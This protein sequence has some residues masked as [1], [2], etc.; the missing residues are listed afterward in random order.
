MTTTLSS[1][2]APPSATPYQTAAAAIAELTHGKGNVE[3]LRILVHSLVTLG[4]DSAARGVLQEV[5]IADPAWPAHRDRIIETLGT[6]GAV[7]W[8]SRQRRFNANLDVLQTRW[9]DLA[10]QLT[11]HWSSTQTRYQLYQTRDGGLQI[12]DRTRGYCFGWL[13]GL[14]D[15]RTERQ[16]WQYPR[17]API[18]LRPMCFDGA[19]YGW[20]LLH[21][22]PD[23]ERSLLSYSCAVY[24]VE[25]DLAALA[26]LLHL[27]DLRHW[28]S[29]P[30]LRLF[31]GAE[32]PN[33]FAAALQREKTWDVPFIHWCNR[34][35]DHPPLD[36]TP[37]C[38]VENARRQTIADAT[39]TTIQSYYQDK[40]LAY[41]RQRYAAALGGG[42]TPLRVLGITT[43]H[44][45]VLQYT[46]DELGQAIRAAGHECQVNKEPDDHSLESA[47]LEQLANFKP[48]LIIAISRLRYENP[49]IPQNVPCLC[50]DQ[51]ALPC[52]RTQRT[53]DSLDALTY[54][55]GSSA[56]EAFMAGRR[57]PLASS[58]FCHLA[59]ATHRYHAAP[60]APEAFARHACDISYVSNASEHPGAF[61]QQLAQRWH[62]SE[63]GTLFS[64]LAQ[65]TLAA[66]AHEE[67]EHVIADGIRD[68]ACQRGHD[69]NL[70]DDIIRELVADL[71]L[72]A[73][74]TLRHTL[75]H[76]VAAYCRKRGRTLRLYGAGWDQTPDLAEFAAGPIT[77]GEDL[78]A[79]YQASKIN[80]QI[81]RWGFTHSRSLDGLAAGGF[82][83]ANLAH[84]DEGHPGDAQRFQFATRA[85]ELGCWTTAEIRASSDPQ[86]R[87]GWPQF[88]SWYS[89]E[90]L[91]GDFPAWRTAAAI[92]IPG[93]VFE[94]LPAISFRDPASFETL[95]ERYL[96]DDTLRQ[97]VTDRMR[98]K[99]LQYYSYDTRW[100]Q[101]ATAILR[102]LNRSG[103]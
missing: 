4:L 80:L 60:V 7:A 1:P 90:E 47:C 8:S 98:Q 12:L 68:L 25:P 94:D 50:W 10:Q 31:G 88:S 3:V 61:A 28:L 16:A 36:L 2:E 65:R 20:L 71:R 103:S 11:D 55:A 30:R 22:L 66:G 100:K 6:T 15:H 17:P 91:A 83:L 59:A 84:N 64:E 70:P 77:P 32:A 23:T 101:F 14:C 39:Q 78:R 69:K 5:Q 54:V 9:P 82:F 93:A 19:G 46:M 76:W 74:R 49:Q 86:L 57:W 75:L 92:A 44:S 27:H 34:L 85:L 41:W 52:M 58:I 13:G 40:D 42:G 89:P 37:L 87:E 38:E 79:L 51:D 97:I 33:Q 35:T 102:G 95:A 81:T 18:F 62:D 63:W 24:L 96:A 26:M 99:V 56:Y 45:T 73:D 67:W 29:A 48:E 43:R 53:T 72:L 21:A